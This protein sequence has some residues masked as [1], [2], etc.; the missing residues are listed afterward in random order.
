M[1]Y[2]VIFWRNSTHK[3][4]FKIQKKIIRIMAG[5]KRESLVENCLR[6]LFPLASEF[7]LSLLSF[8]VDNRKRFTF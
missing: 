6:N 7:L 5:I 2:G 8:V 1:P 3:R 4:V